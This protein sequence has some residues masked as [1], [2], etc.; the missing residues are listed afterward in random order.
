MKV[1]IVGAGNVGAT[2]ADVI[3]YR[4]IASE[5]VL[6]DIKEG[7]AEGKALD[8][9][10]CATNTGFN[11]KVSGVTNDYSKTAGSDV[12]V[13]T[14]GIPRKPGMTRE[15][16][17]G[18]NAGIVKTVAENVLKY[19][20][21]TIIVVVSNPMDTMTYLALKATGL[22]KNRIIGMGGAL[23]SSRFRTYLSLALDKPAND[24]SA[25][26]IGGHGD[27]TMIPLTRLA[28]YNGIPVSQFLSEDVLQKVA[29]DTMV[30]GAT[31]TGLLGTSAWYAPG[32]S[33][34]YLVDSIL[35]DQKKMIACSV[36]V[37][38]EYGQNDICIGVPCIIGKNGVEEIV[39]INLNDQ[40]KAL[41]AKSADAVR[42]MNDA[43][44]SILV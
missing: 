40:E 41:F 3:S 9:T 1:T 39:D 7:F 21:D 11:T 15:E 24:I 2:C 25:M 44:K 32:A 4:G 14:S 22:P 26:V 38:G 17:I 10:Q 35:N 30:G 33:V 12:V 42:G 19:S 37:E 16:L 8:I 36:F 23:D 34:A 18:I 20:P 13:I 5:V 31:L 29:A 27:T 6:L 28:S 43:L